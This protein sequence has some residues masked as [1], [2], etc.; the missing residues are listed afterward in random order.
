MKKIILILAVFVFSSSLF[1][2][3][4]PDQILGVWLN[5]TNDAKIKI[6]KKDNRYYGKI[7][8]FAMPDEKVIAERTNKK[9]IDPKLIEKKM[10][11]MEILSNLTYDDGE[12]VDG[13]IYS[14]KK[15]QKVDC[16]IEL[17]D[18]GKELYLTASKGLLF[19]KTV[20]WTRVDK[21]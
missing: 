10:M 15:D 6:I 21:D 12:W 3:S 20:T 11:G 2:Q 8:W 14:P 19:S 7:F 4:G 1:G 17:S 5:H 9:N 18:D 16:E 13:T